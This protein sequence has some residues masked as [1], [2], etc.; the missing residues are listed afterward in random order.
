MKTSYTNTY[1]VAVC[2]ENEGQYPA[3]MFTYD[4]AFDPNGPRVAE[5]NK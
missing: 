1:V 4:P 5:V 3:L 2:L